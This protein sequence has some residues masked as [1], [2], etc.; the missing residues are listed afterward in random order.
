MN[1]QINTPTNQQQDLAG[2]VLFGGDEHSQE[3][4]IE[5]P[6]G[7]PGFEVFTRFKISAL[8]DY[9]PFCVLQSEDEP[10]ISMLIIEVKFLTIQEKIVI[11]DKELRKVNIL[12]GQDALVFLILK[13]NHKT[14]ELTA[15]TRAPLVIN[16]EAKKGFQAI[17][18]DASLPLEYSLAKGLN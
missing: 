18:E 7:L 16:L 3:V 1:E 12:R 10:A 9:Q 6:F 2:S 8:Q 13:V 14:H 11:P 15:N 17:L 4:K 5:F